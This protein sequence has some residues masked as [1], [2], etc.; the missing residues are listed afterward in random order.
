MATDAVSPRPA[1]EFGRGVVRGAIAVALATVVGVT[2]WWAGERAH[3]ND[4]SG[5]P[6]LVT[7]AVR[8]V[9]TAATPALWLTGLMWCSIVKRGRRAALGMFLVGSGLAVGGITIAGVRS[10]AAEDLTIDQG[11]GPVLVALPLGAFA[12]LMVIS[13]LIVMATARAASSRPVAVPT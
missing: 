6:L 11:G 3:A 12:V 4:T 10:A 1:P 2:A 5:R 7:E 9:L 8:S 13:G